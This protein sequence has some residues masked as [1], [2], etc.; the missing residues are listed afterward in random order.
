[1]GSLEIDAVLNQ[2]VA[3]LAEPSYGTTYP[4]ETAFEIDAWPRIV[5]LARQ[6]GFDCLT[7][8]T[9]HADRSIA[10][11][12]SSTRCSFAPALTRCPTSGAIRKTGVAP[13]ALRFSTPGAKRSRSICMSTVS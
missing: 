12:A 1:M 3:R 5:S 10:K 7:S 13:S 6:L 9:V 4:D 2:I 8:H 11:S